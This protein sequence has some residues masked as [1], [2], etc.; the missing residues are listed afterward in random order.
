MISPMGGARSSIV[1]ASLVVASLAGCDSR[2]KASDPAGGRAEAKS[3]EY[4][5]CSASVHCQDELRCFSNVCRRVT[6]STVGDY[7]AALGAAAKARG[8]LEAAIDAYNRALGHYDN[9]KIALP[10]DVDC[11]YGS[12]L[13]A[14]RAKK[15]H[16]ELAAR[17]L[18]R[19][20]LAVPVGSPLR[21]VALAEAATLT[22]A[23]LDPLALGRAQL[24]DVY[25]TRAPQKPSTDKLQVTIAPSPPVAKKTFPLVIERLSQPDMKTALV[26][27]WD[28]YNAASK[29]TTMTATV[30]VKWSYIPSEYDDE[31]G[32]YTSKIEPGVAMPPGPEAAANQCV[33]AAVEPVLKALTTVRDSFSTNL[34]ITVK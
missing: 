14:A 24:A 9:E 4:E 21:Q 23:G 27:C 33:E 3:K 6:R 19:C 29:K 22:E 31:P 15:E 11:A 7:F 25:L 5:S 18:H 26:A 13:A 34:T 30:G 28:V 32:R 16:A 8:E 20:I 17:V 1:F 10:P 12:T 2:A